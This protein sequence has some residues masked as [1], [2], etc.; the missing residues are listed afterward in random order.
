MFFSDSNGIPIYSNICEPLQTVH[1][2][3]SPLGGMYW[4][5]SGIGVPLVGDI[6]YYIIGA[7][8]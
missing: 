3:S 5:H 6:S 1:H 8:D 4:F 7:W 2:H